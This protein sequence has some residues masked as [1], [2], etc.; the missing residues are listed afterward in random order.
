MNY[1]E[2]QWQSKERRTRYDAHCVDI[3]GVSYREGRVHIDT[4]PSK[5]RTVRVPGIAQGGR[6][7][8]LRNVSLE[9]KMS[10]CRGV[11][12]SQAEASSYQHEVYQ[13]Q[14]HPRG[15]PCAAV[16]HATL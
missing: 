6:G 15:E 5:I 16:P 8:W 2:L 10:L 1:S 13:R 11:M 14:Y 4:H 3:S 7:V 9:L 12:D